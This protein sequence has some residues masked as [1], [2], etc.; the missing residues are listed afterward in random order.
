[1]KKTNSNFTLF[2]VSILFRESLNCLT[3]THRDDSK[4]REISLPWEDY[5]LAIA[6]LVAKRS[7]SPSLQLGA[8]IVNKDNCIIGQGYNGMPQGCSDDI[9]PWGTDH[10]D[11]LE[12]KYLYGNVKNPLK[13]K[14]LILLSIYV[15]KDYL[16]FNFM[17]HYQMTSTKYFC[18]RMSC[19][20]KCNFK[21][22]CTSKRLHYV[23][24]CLPMQ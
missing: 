7:K 20:I 15:L 19:R 16:P 9:F 3:F 18:F 1:M 10:E 24:Y 22:W 17:R 14:N 2:F 13:Y 4:K 21:C 11:P 8:C 6:I 5:F 23:H 12:N